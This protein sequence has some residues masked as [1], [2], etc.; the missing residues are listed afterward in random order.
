MQERATPIEAHSTIKV[1][2]LVTCLHA[3]TMTYV[4]VQRAV[5]VTIYSTGNNYDRF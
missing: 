5:S 1:E 4:Y 3:T 2:Q